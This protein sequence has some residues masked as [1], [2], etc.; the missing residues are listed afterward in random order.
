MAAFAGELIGARL[1]GTLLFQDPAPGPSWSHLAAMHQGGRS[2]Q[3]SLRHGLEVPDVTSA[4]LIGQS[5]LQLAGF[6]VDSTF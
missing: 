4:T 2:C 3:L 1:T 6:G 5:S